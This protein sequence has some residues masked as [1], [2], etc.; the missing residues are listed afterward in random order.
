MERRLTVAGL[1]ALIMI[2]ACG[3]GDRAAAAGDS[4]VQ[5]A[6]AGAVDITPAPAPTKPLPK[7]ACA[8]DNGGLT[9][10]AGFCAVI[11]ADRLGGARH[12]V[13]AP[14]GDVFV[15]RSFAPRGA[16]TVLSP[17]GGIVGMRDTSGDGRADVLQ[18]FGG[19]GGT[20]IALSNGQLWAD[21]KTAIVRYA[22]PDGSLRP[23]SAPDTIVSGLPTGGHEAHNIAVDGKGA[24]FVNVGSRTNSCQEKDRQPESRGVDPCVELETRAG[25]W[26]FDANK[27]HQPFAA[28]NRFATGIRNAVGMTVNGAD[29][30]LYATQHGRDQLAGSWPKL[31]TTERNAEQPQEALMRVNRGDD[32]GWPYCFYNGEVNKLVAAPEFG[33]DGTTVGRCASK[34]A[35]IAT[36]PGHWAPN[37]LLIYTG[38]QFPARF[39][40]GAFIA[41]HGSWN[42][43]PLP[44]A[45]FRVTFVPAT[46]GRIG[47]AYETF[48]DGFAPDVTKP[49]HR[50]TGLAQ[51]PDGSLYVTD[52]R[53]GRVWRVWYVGKS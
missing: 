11:V 2:A 18:A 37:A 36:F 24:L 50:P 23:S 9:L 12:I 1:G 5:S 8:A 4:I 48:A 21:A 32:F 19:V 25:I 53:G 28:S 38:S 26:R 22:L 30:A 3:R 27:P 7:S 39:R 10:P 6:S 43:A 52:D 47:R 49:E 20:G 15:T 35:P 31:F 13:V 40:N 45:G 41:F 29:G 51:G 14:N 44:N 16:D 33:G 17:K 34:K 42:R 46:N